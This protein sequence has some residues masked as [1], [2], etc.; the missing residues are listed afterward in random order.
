VLRQYHGQLKR[1]LGRRYRLNPTLPD[2]EYV[3]ELAR[4]RPDLDTA[5]LARL[6]GR[7]QTADVSEGEMVTLAQQAAAWLHN[8]RR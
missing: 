3:A 5:A 4:F 8:G 6:L 7:L 2:D 1:E